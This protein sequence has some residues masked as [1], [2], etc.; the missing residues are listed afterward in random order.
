MPEITFPERP[1]V[2]AAEIKKLEAEAAFLDA[3]RRSQEI[4]IQNQLEEIEDQKATSEENGIYIFYSPIGNTSAG[5]CIQTLG[6]WARRQ[7]ADDKERKP[8]VI[9]FCSPGGD[10]ISGFALIDYVHQLRTRGLEVNTLGLGMVASMAAICLQAGQTRTMSENAY[11][12]IHEISG[13]AVGSLSE[14]EDE[15]KFFKRLNERGYNIL[16]ERSKLDAREIAKRAKRK[17]WWLD[18]DEALEYGLID[19]IR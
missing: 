19:E 15:S 3:R 2:D 10:V 17:D 9:E 1:A 16:A 7:E 13:G 12:L 8:F 5:V 6:Y 4:V 11:M 14:I 18:A